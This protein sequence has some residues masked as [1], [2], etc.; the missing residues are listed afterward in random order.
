MLTLWTRRTTLY[1]SYA[2][3]CRRARAE[4]LRYYEDCYEMTWQGPGWDWGSITSKRPEQMIYANYESDRFVYLSNAGHTFEFNNLNF[5]IDVVERIQ[6]I[7]IYG[8]DF[9]RLGLQPNAMRIAITFAIGQLKDLI[10][11]FGWQGEGGREA[12]E[13]DLFRE[14]QRWQFS[15]GLKSGRHPLSLKWDQT[16][17]PMQA[18]LI[19]E[20]VDEVELATGYMTSDSTGPDT[21]SESRPSTAENEGE[22]EKTK[23]TSLLE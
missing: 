5:S 7:A 14:T 23:E 9:R 20:A 10:I 2:A 1:S 3:T 4:G 18:Y 11:L 21:L 19:W 8:H 17:T 13:G 12:V 15:G 6:H 16:K 22:T